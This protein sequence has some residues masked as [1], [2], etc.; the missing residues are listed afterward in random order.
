METE[1]ALR[2]LVDDLIAGVEPAAA[3]EALLGAGFVSGPGETSASA[4]ASLCQSALN[5]EPALKPAQVQHQLCKEGASPGLAADLVREVTSDERPGIVLGELEGVSVLQ[6]LGDLQT[7]PRARLRLL[8][9][10]LLEP[11]F[12]R[13]SR[14]LVDL[15]GL[16]AAP[17]ELW[18]L[19]L[20]DV[21]AQRGAGGE[22]V[23]CGADPEVQEQLRAAR[24]LDL[25]THEPDPA[26]A[27]AAMAALPVSPVT[28]GRFSLRKGESSGVPILL[29]RGSLDPRSI[30]RAARR[31]REVLS[32][33]G[34]LVL[35]CAEVPWIS[36]EGFALLAEIQ[37]ESA[38]G[39][40]QVARLV[41]PAALAAATVG[42]EEGLTVVSK[43]SE[44]LAACAEAPSSGSPRD[45]S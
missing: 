11:L 3:A 24:V 44:A 1:G 13:D 23:L 33:A 31:L 22:L 38:P 14:L 28:A 19:L 30:P 8:S 43:R 6:P 27:L 10:R 34:R 17:L 26:R 21:F 4:L 20:A 29:P 9:S 5:A 36:R 12:A 40:F 2:Q 45:P 37:A 41:G 15:S 7:L 42:A 35:D 16:C 18:G 25:V 32:E 39:A